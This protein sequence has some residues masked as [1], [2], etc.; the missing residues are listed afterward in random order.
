[1]HDP[2]S[3]LSLDHGYLSSKYICDVVMYF[4]TESWLL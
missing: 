3:Y 1:M 2:V 4:V